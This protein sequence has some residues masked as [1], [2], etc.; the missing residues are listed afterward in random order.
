VY[1]VKEVET[2]AKEYAEGVR[3]IERAIDRDTEKHTRIYNG[4]VIAQEDIVHE[5]VSN[6]A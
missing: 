5:F 2:R 6:K 3:D 1:E 4:A